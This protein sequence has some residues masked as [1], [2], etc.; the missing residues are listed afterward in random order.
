MDRKSEGIENSFEK[1]MLY[2]EMGRAK[3]QRD[4]LIN[5]PRRNPYLMQLKTTQ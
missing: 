3:Q 2:V 1:G 4:N 5:R